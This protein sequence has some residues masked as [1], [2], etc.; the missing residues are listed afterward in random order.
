M[1]DGKVKWV[2]IGFVTAPHGVNGVL[3]VFPATDF[4]N[5]FR[6]V[7][8]IFLNYGESRRRFDVFKAGS[9]PRGMVSLALRGLASRDDAEKWRGASVQ[10]PRD[11][12]VTL[13]EGH[14]Y[15]FDLIG[16]TV[17]TVEGER[18]GT[19]KDVYPTGANDVYSVVT[20]D[21]VELLIPAL[22]QVVRSID[23]NERRIV[24]DPPPGLLD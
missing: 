17:F 22:K 23:T 12:A 14:F 1:T 4:P 3:R 11:E 2:T 19:L 21:R 13:P 8:R 15:V 10:V 5:R 6:E 18:L 24:V 16:C 20:D 9:L 7:R